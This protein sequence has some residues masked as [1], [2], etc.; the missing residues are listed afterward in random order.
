MDTRG[1][2]YKT[3]RSVIDESFDTIENDLDRITRIAQVVEDLCASN[4]SEF[5]AACKDICKYNQYRLREFQQEQDSTLP[6]NLFNFIQS[7]IQ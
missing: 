4:L 7:N 6:E 2:H 3:F 1:L 5:L